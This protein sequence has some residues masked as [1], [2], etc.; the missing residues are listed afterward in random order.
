MTLPPGT[1]HPA[2]P[3]TTVVA[4]FPDGRV[5]EGPVG[6]QLGDFVSAASGSASV[7]TMAALVNGRLCELTAQLF[8]DVAVVPVTVADN[9]GSRIYRRSLAFLMLTAASEVLPD[10]EVF[11]EHAAPLVGG[12]FC[13]VRGR[14][15]FGQEELGQIEARMREIVS[16]DARYFTQHGCLADAWSA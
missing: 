12:Y 9:D 15:P 10:A 13:E 5:F 8:H 11:V 3:R 1:V 4:T 2:A 6:A 7:P 14:S 16:Q